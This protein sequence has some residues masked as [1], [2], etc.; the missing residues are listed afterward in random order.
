MGQMGLIIMFS[1]LVMIWA[2]LLQKYNAN[3][4]PD[5]AD[6]KTKEITSANKKIKYSLFL[7][8]LAILMI[9]KGYFIQ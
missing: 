3:R 2:S 9:I 1:C 7:I 6:L 5:F 4:L 8:A